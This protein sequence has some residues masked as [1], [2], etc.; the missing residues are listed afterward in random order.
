[1][2]FLDIIKKNRRNSPERGVTEKRRMEMKEQ[3]VKTYYQW[4]SNYD[5]SQPNNNYEYAASPFIFEEHYTLYDHL[6]D[7]GINYIVNDDN[8]LEY[9][10][11]D[12][13]WLWTGERY[14]I[15][16]IVV[17]TIIEYTNF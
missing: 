15:T 10:I 8:E 6:K 12:N 3:N 14:L 1:M 13:D 7:N 11:L 4:T 16:K 5:E 2:C 17:I 9:V